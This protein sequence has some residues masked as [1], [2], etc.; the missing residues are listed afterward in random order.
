MP[1]PAVRA[2]IRLEVLSPPRTNLVDDLASA[3]LRSVGL[4]VAAQIAVH[5]SLPP[6]MLRCFRLEAF[7]GV[8]PTCQKPQSGQR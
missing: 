4:P 8:W 3:I 1:E 7:P 6:R 5:Q 2:M